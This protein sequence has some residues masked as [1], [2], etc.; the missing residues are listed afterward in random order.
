LNAACPHQ[1]TQNTQL[2]PIT[3]FQLSTH[4]NIF[5]ALSNSSRFADESHVMRYM[6]NLISDSFPS[7][8]CTA[9]FSKKFIVKLLLFIFATH[10]AM[11]ACGVPTMCCEKTKNKESKNNNNKEKRGIRSIRTASTP[12]HGA[13]QLINIFRAG[14]VGSRTSMTAFLAPSLGAKRSSTWPIL[15]APTGTHS[16]FT[17][18]PAS[19]LCAARNR[20]NFFSL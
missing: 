17:G 12:Q 13:L 3:H 19:F 7:T 16:A 14:G 5:N 4:F 20:F 11:P 1:H 2:L 6:F 18:S 8:P 15:F 9:I 10:C